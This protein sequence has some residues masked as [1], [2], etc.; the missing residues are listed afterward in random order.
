MP[1]RFAI[2]IGEEMMH[3]AAKIVGTEEEITVFDDI[4]YMIITPITATEY[5][6]RLMSEEEMFTEFKNDGDLQI[7][8]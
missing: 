6:L 7:V 5:N 2:R 4:P 3:A 8:N 1:Q